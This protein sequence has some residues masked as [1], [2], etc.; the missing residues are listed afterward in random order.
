MNDAILPTGRH[1]RLA[2]ATLLSVGLLLFVLPVASARAGTYPM[3]QCRDAAGRAISIRSDWTVLARPGG[4]IHNSCAKNGT[5][6]IVPTPAG[7]TGQEG[8]SDLLLT[9][10]PSAPHVRFGRALLRLRIAPKT[11]D[12]VLSYGHVVLM[13][14]GQPLEGQ[15]LSAGATGWIDRAASPMESA[16]PIGAKSVSVRLWCYMACQFA[17]YQAVQIQQALLTLV[18]NEAPVVG[19]PGGSLMARGARAGTHSL[20]FE[21][22]DA[23]SGVRRTTILADGT[24]IAVDDLGGRCHYD[25]FAPCPTAT[26]QRLVNVDTSRLTAG[27]HRV[28]LRAEDAAGNVSYKDAGDIVVVATAGLAAPQRVAQ[29]AALRARYAVSL[30]PVRTLKW[31]QRFVTKGR[32]RA[33][34]GKPIAHAAVAAV[35]AGPRAPRTIGRVRTSRGGSWS[36][37]LRARFRSGHITFTYVDGR[38]GAA[39]ARLLAKVRAGVALR[40]RR[41]TVTPH[42]R[43]RLSGRLLGRPIPRRGKVVEIRARGRG[44]KR[45][46]TFKTVRSDRRGR[47]AVTHRLTQGYRNVTYEFQAVARYDAAYPYERGASNVERVTVR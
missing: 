35:V 15:A 26:Q 38:G 5:F 7:S 19:I 2:A 21:V 28:V 40:A 24:P 13:S 39:Y 14:D 17:S 43:I 45:W 36:M 18:E 25:D 29:V 16:T 27:V 22:G 41:H 46:I 3:Y 6:G 10:P 4:I 1:G 9:V 32:L 23:D 8:T 33:L 37:P 44:E 30:N 12:P 47:F 20:T 42:G 31:N 11:G 34:D